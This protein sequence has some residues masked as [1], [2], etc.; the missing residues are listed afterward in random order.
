VV[1]AI[2]NASPNKYSNLKQRCIMKLRSDYKDLTGQ[3]FFN[4]VAIRPVDRNIMRGVEWLCKCD[5]GNETYAYGGHLRSNKRKS[6]GCISGS[7]IEETGIKLIMGSY[8]KKA[9]ERNFEFKL[10]LDEFKK[11]IKSNCFYCGKE[12][13][14]IWRRPKK[15]DE[16]QIIW[17]GI[18][19]VDSLL[20][21][22]IDNCVSA[23]KHCNRVKSNMSLQEFKDH[24]KRIYEWLSIGF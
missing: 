13:S 10:S 7:R 22:V 3:R 9:F 14:Q 11:L 4:L 5:C 19:R 1:S 21:Y 6:C 12:P 2:L 17:N 24:I 18:D 16:I 8:K 15:R 20:G 23:C